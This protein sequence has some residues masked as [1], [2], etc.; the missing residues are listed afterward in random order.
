MSTSLEPGST[1]YGDPVVAEVDVAYDPQTVDAAGIRVQPDFT[2]YVATAAPSVRLT[3]DGRTAVASYRYTL[4]CVTEG[5]LPTGTRRRVTFKPVRVTGTAAGQ[6]VAASATWPSLAVT[7]PSY[8]C[9]SQRLDPLPAPV[10]PHPAGLRRR[11][12]PPRGPPDRRRGAAGPRGRGARRPGAADGVGVRPPPARSRRST[13]PSP[14]RATRPGGPTRRT[15]AGRSSCSPRRSPPGAS[16]GS[17]A[18]PPIRHGRSR[19]RRR[20]ARSSSPIAS[21][22]EGRPPH[23]RRPGCRCPCLRRRGGANGGRPLG[24]G[25]ALVVL[26]LLAALVARHPAPADRASLPVRSG[27]MIVLDLSASISSDTFSRIGETL[28][29][30]SQQQRPLRARRL[31]ERRLRGA[32]AGHAGGGAQAARPL[33][34]PPGR[35]RARARRRPSRRTRGARASAAA[36]ASRPGSTWRTGSSSRTTSDARGSC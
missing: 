16:R 7:V 15:G 23:E 29:R 19:R 22:H 10:D 31:L 30:L 8:A 1:R 20:P 13:W 2:P 11:P 26:V 33:L 17:R 4:L 5:C 28:R 25:V 9:R 12:G 21:R 3:A 36:R 18:T 34:H 14:T 32:P 27:D 6:S 35:R 24:P